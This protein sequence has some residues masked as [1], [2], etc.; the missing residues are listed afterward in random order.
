ME[1]KPLVGVINILQH[2][3]DLDD[4]FVSMKNYSLSHSEIYTAWQHSKIVTYEANVHC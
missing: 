4:Y 3:V 1:N 2:W